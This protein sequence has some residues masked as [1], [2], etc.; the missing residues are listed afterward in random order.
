VTAARGARNQ[1]AT[2]LRIREKPICGSAS[3]LALIASN[4]LYRKLQIYMSRRRV[5]KIGDGFSRRA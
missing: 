3:Q 1:A 2:F 5:E 4:F